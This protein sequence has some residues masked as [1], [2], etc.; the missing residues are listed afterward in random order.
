MPVEARPLSTRPGHP[1]ATHAH[2][3]RSRS[4]GTASTRV[5]CAVCI[6]T[7]TSRADLSEEGIVIAAD[8]HAPGWD[9]QRIDH[10][11]CIAALGLA[12]SARPYAAATPGL[13][14][15]DHTVDSDRCWGA[16]RAA[17]N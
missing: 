15:T 2:G 17:R 6:A 11:L 9:G 4:H 10:D 12:G 5:T 3:E 13:A 7:S 1:T 8:T 14:S 16:A